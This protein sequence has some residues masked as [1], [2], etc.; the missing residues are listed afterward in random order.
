MK[1]RDTLSQGLVG[2]GR[3]SKS[4]ETLAFSTLSC[5]QM[6]H[7]LVYCMMS[8]C[9]FSKKYPF[10]LLGHMFFATQGVRPIRY[11]DIP[12]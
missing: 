1:S 8:S 12:E 10:F 4:P 3:G 5:W 2:I 7:V 9:I 6:R 11:H